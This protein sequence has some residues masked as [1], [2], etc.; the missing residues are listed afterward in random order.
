MSPG[1]REGSSTAAALAVPTSN[2]SPSDSNLENR[3]ARIADGGKSNPSVLLGGSVSRG[4]PR[5]DPASS[6]N[7]Q[8]SEGGWFHHIVD[9]YGAIELDNKG[10]VARD[11]LALGK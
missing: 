1:R 2:G 4:Q 7:A 10:S 11:H 8:E 3:R 5:E 9:K 6:S